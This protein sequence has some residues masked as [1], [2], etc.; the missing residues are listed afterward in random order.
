MK[1]YVL[2]MLFPWKDPDGSGPFYCPDCGIVEGFFAYS[3][4]V[5]EKIDIQTLHFEKPRRAV[6]ALL[7]PENQ[8]CPA[9][10]LPS[11]S[12]VPE[13]GKT[14]LSTG[15]VFID[16]PVTICKFLAKTFDAVPPH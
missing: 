8:G 15:A 9:L 13:G 12:A 10:V 5:R 4:E 14:S 1:E 6:A 7:G 3:P 11:G 2:F 16:D